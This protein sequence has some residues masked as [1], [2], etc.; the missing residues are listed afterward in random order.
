MQ[1]KKNGREDAN[2][3]DEEKRALLS[4]CR[5]LICSGNLE[6]EAVLIDGM[7]DDNDFPGGF[8]RVHILLDWEAIERSDAKDEIGTVRKYLDHIADIQGDKAP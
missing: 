8:L 3:V 6:S 2:P 7:Y 1:G 4:F 5:K